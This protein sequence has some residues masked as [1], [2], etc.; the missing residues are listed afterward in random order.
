MPSFMPMQLDMKVMQSA[1][2]NIL[3]LRFFISLVF[4]FIE[5]ELMGKA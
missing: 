1:A 4:K 3:P 2:K 5:K